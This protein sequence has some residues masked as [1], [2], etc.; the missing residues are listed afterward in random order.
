MMAIGQD[1]SAFYRG[2]SV[3]AIATLQRQTK[4]TAY[5]SSKQLLLSAFNFVHKC[6]QQQL[7]VYF[8]SKQ[9]L[10]VTVRFF[11]GTYIFLASQCSMR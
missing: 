10:T 1:L 4:V 6:K 8:S 3:L 7:H 9:L 11:N 5:F 2:R